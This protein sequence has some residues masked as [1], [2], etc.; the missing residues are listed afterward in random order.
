MVCSNRQ[1]NAN[2]MALAEIKY[3]LSIGKPVVA[4]Q[5][6]QSTG[7]YI[8]VLGV[9]VI[10]RRKDSVENWITENKK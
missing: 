7:A 3:A 8:N 10:P 1:A 6:M 4:I 5:T 9:P 2:G